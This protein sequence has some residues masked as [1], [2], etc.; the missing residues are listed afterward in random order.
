MAFLVANVSENLAARI[1][2]KGRKKI[3]QGDFNISYFQVGDSEFD[4]T[5]P[6]YEFDGDVN[7]SQKVL[8]PFD[9]DSQV[10]YPYKY[11][12]SSLT[13]TTYGTPVQSASWDRITNYLSA[14]GFVSDYSGATIDATYEAVDISVINGTNIL[15]VLNGTSYY[16]I[17]FITIFFG[18]L[19]IGGT[20]TNEVHSSLTYKITEIVGNDLYLDRPMPDL[21]SL[22][23]NVTIISNALSSFNPCTDQEY[24]WD[25]NT[26]W[27]KTPAGL[28]PAIVPLTSFESN[29][30][31]SAKEYFGYNSS[32]GQTDNTL[33][34][35]TNTFGNEIIVPPEEQHSISILHYSKVGV[36]SLDPDLPYKYEDYLGHNEEETEYFEIYIP[37]ILYD[38]NV[39]TTIG[40]RFFMDTEDYYI[41]SSA[42][43]TKPN[44]MKFRYLI[45]EQGIK[46]GKVFV[47]HKVIIFDDQEIVA[48][49]DYKSNR[50]YTLPI[51]QIST[52]PVD[53][54]CD[55]NGY[56]LTPLLSGGTTGQTVF[57]TYLLQENYQHNTQ[58]AADP[59]L[60]GMCCNYYSKI[61]YSTVDSDVS[62]KFDTD[63]FQFMRASF[64]EATDGY[65]ADTFQILVQVVNTGEQPDPTL[66][67][68]IDFTDQIPN[69]TVG[70]LITPANIRDARFIITSS[71]YEN[72]DIY[73][74]P[75]TQFGDFQSFPGSVKV[76]RVTD[77]EVMRFLINLPSGYFETTQ[78]PSYDA[79]VVPAIPKRITEVALLDENKDVLVIAKASSPIEK[80]GTM[81]LAIQLDI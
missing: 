50:N 48:A 32:S 10:K 74:M 34:T 45:D 37:F 55:V 81:V 38:R 3:A 54:K 5:T 39:D 33:T 36:A 80:V 58:S 24:S 13:G 35:I 63:D 1:T 67:R 59:Q 25:L 20:I 68:I 8:M 2:N 65:I 76:A 42:S 19:G 69:H 51:P 30:F 53:S 70:D 12:E 75:E 18:E 28:D 60:S 22:S 71:D 44:Q 64:A 11:S 46:V 40:A 31:V 29:V 26:V 66:W 56:L 78:N 43:D 15:S 23:G 9:K 77:M 17:E 4:Y 79:T 7:A 41:N 47:N 62:I 16:N 73:V 72:A 49:L 14:V 6:F 57:V 61:S 27:S 52:V 21:S